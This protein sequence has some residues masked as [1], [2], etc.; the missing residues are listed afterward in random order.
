MPETVPL[1]VLPCPKG[2]SLKVSVYVLPEPE[3]LMVPP[4][5]AGKVLTW[6][7]LTTV[8]CTLANS[9]VVFVLVAY[10]P[11]DNELLPLAT[12]TI[13][14]TKVLLPD[15]PPPVAGEISPFAKKKVA[16]V[17]PSL[18]LCVNSPFEMV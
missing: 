4:T 7:P 14:I 9:E 11:L 6:P 15:T 17:F 3:I 10:S 8:S 5:N 1:S 16:S 13:L 18:E 2:T 12:A